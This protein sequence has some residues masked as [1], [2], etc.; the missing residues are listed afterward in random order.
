MPPVATANAGTVGAA[1]DYRLR[2]ELGPCRSDQFV[3]DLRRSRLSTHIAALLPMMDDFFGGLDAFAERTQPWQG[4]LNPADERLLARYCVVLAL[5]E[6]STASVRFRF[7]L[8]P[9]WEHGMLAL[10]GDPSSQDVMNLRRTAATTF[11]KLTLASQPYIPNPTFAGSRDVGGADTDFVLG[12]CLWEVKTT[13]NLDGS[14]IRTAS[15]SWWV[16]SCWTA[17]TRTVSGVYAGTS[18]RHDY[19]WAPPLWAL[20]FPPAQVVQWLRQDTT[21]DQTEVDE[22]L[23]RLRR[24]MRRVSHGEAIE[25]EVESP[26]EGGAGITLSWGPISQTPLP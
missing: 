13:K 16:T 17:K 8:A 15:C 4:R 24:L 26:V 23:A 11:R 2:Y 21:P 18:P 9:A 12:D 14:A 7:D 25:Y 10:A 6:A 19:L 20:L 5:L 22:R 3:A 1:F